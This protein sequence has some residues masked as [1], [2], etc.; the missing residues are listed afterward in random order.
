MARPR[1]YD[2]RSKFMVRLPPALH[3]QLTDAAAERELAANVLVCRAIERYLEQLVPVDDLLIT[4]DE[5][6]PASQRV[7]RPPDGQ[8]SPMRHVG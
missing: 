3:Q 8:T 6:P 1:E 2:E 7:A 5:P 4:R